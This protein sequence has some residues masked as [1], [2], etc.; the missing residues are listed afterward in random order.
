MNEKNIH[1]ALSVLDGITYIM[2]FVELFINH[3]ISFGLFLTFIS[4]LLNL[5]L[6]GMHNSD[7]LK[8]HIQASI[9]TSQY[10]AAAKRYFT[11]ITIGYIIIDSVAIYIMLFT[12]YHLFTKSVLALTIIPICYSCLSMGV[13]YY[14]VPDENSYRDIQFIFSSAPHAIIMIGSFFDFSI[15]T[16]LSAIIVV[17]IF[18]FPVYIVSVYIRNKM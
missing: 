4:M 15:W 11:W 17:G 18:Y 8:K 12:R 10:S 1:T 6:W 14:D 5:T 9:N 16:I 3:R 2:A 7:K 13:K